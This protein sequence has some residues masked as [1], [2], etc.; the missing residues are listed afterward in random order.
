[1]KV[2]DATLSLNDTG[3]SR[4]RLELAS[5]PQNMHIDALVGTIFVR[6]YCLEKMFTPKR[7]LRC[8]EKGGQQGI[9]FLR[10]RHRG[11]VGVGQPLH[12]LLKL[13][14]A[15]STDAGWVPLKC[16]ATCFPA[17]QNRPEVPA[18]VTNIRFGHVIAHISNAGACSSPP[19]AP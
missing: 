17:V 3:K 19:A 2:P 12:T 7:A 14:A 16:K 10:Q 9:L 8:L 15:K 18:Q 6:A 5:Q 4:V 11:S 1:M 13:P